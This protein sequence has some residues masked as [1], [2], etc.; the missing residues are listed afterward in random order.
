MKKFSLVLLLTL[1]VLVIG[2]THLPP[3]TEVPDDLK[4]TLD[5]IFGLAP[6]GDYII[7]INADG[8]G[9]LVH[10]LGALEKKYNFT[11]TDEE[12]LEI[13]NTAQDNGFYSMAETNV[14][15]TVLDAGGSRVEIMMNGNTTSVS[16]VGFGFD[17]FYTIVEKIEQVSSQRVGF[18]FFEPQTLI[19]LCKNV[20]EVCPKA[21]TLECDIAIFD[22]ENPGV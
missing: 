18:D 6:P 11:V 15:Q 10:T 1:L 8:S 16:A 20:N 9:E 19:D 14:D 3:I 2:C 21:D 12:L 7:V 13:L 22:C 4:I 17:N 5:P